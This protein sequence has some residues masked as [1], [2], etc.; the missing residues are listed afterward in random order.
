MVDP[1]IDSGFDTGPD[2]SLDTATQNGPDTR[3]LHEHVLNGRIIDQRQE[4]TERVPRFI[5]ELGRAL[6]GS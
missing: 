6:A 1:G 5:T 2:P 3:H 4:A